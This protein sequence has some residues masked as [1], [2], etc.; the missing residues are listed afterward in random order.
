MGTDAGAA[1]TGLPSSRD[2]AVSNRLT[3]FVRARDRHGS[4]Q[5]A[6]DCLRRF[7]R[8]PGQYEFARRNALIE[9]PS[10]PGLVDI[11]EVNDRILRAR[12][13][14][15]CPAANMPHGHIRRSFSTSA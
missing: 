8:R 3:S 10:E 1:G 11:K 6:D 7:G 5:V 14:W 12:G 2:A 4:L 13:E 15:M 9:Y